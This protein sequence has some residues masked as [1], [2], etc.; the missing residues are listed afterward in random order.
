MGASLVLATLQRSVPGANI[1]G[2]ILKHTYLPYFG[3]T[4]LAD[5][6][7]KATSPQVSGRIYA[8]NYADPTPGRLTTAV[9]NMQTAY[10]D[11]AGRASN[12]VNVGAGELGGRTLHPG[13][14]QFTTGV[15][16]TSNLVL[17]GDCDDVFIFQIP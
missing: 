14:Y 3:H 16:V 10:N 15:R 13:V 12:F 8:A 9:N 17:T 4:H 2:P 7:Q 6:L 11:A 1:V 5:N